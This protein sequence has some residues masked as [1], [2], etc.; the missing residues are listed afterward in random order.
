MIVD[1]DDDA[2]DD[3]D[4]DDDDDRDDNQRK[5]FSCIPALFDLG[6][7]E[8]LELYCIRATSTSKA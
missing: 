3:D 7:I 8:P 5:L 2:C 4:D 6:S 1:N